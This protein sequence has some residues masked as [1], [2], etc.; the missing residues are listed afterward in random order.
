MR[1]DEGRFLSAETVGGLGADDGLR[2]RLLVGPPRGGLVGSLPQFQFDEA[3]LDLAPEG[4]KADA[5]VVLVHVE[6]GDRLTEAA[7]EE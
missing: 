1:F 6:A 5:L 4:L 7:S 2:H 3:V